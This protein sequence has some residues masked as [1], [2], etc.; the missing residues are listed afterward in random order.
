MFGSFPFLSTQL[1]HF[2]HKILEKQSVRAAFPYILVGIPMHLRPFVQP[3]HIL[4]S[5]RATFP[6]SNF[7]RFLYR[8]TFPYTI[9]QR[10][11]I[12]KPS[13]AQKMWITFSLF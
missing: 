8:A 9:V 13:Y 5:K 3:P 4:F 1:P 2:F 12:A 10:S 11:H 7:G 6:Y